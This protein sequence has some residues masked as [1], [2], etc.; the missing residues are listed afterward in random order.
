M[1][2]HALLNLWPFLILNKSMF[3]KEKYIAF[4]IAVI[5]FLLSFTAAAQLKCKI[6]YFS[7]EDGLSHDAVTYLIKDREGFMWFSTWNGI[8]RFDGH[9]FISY[10]S[11]PGD[12]SELKHDRIDVIA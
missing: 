4:N 10:K 12:S 1:A 8:S 6:E 9:N 3:G 11:S 2:T 5:A 7:T